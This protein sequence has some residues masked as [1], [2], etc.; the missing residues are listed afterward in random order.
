[1][2]CENPITCCMQDDNSLTVVYSKSMVT[3]FSTII[4]RVI[5]DSNEKAILK[6]LI[7]AGGDLKKIPV[8]GISPEMLRQKVKLAL[9][10]FSE[11]LKD[12]ESLLEE[13]CM[14]KRRLA[15]ANN[16]IDSDNSLS[17]IDEE[18]D[19]DSEGDD[20]LIS[21]IR[22]S[23]RLRTGLQS[24]GVKRLSDIENYS[25]MDY[26][27]IE[28]IGAKS[29]YELKGICESYGLTLRGVPQDLPADQV[30]VDDLPYTR[31][32]KDALKE[33]GINTLADCAKYREDQLY[34][35]LGQKNIVRRI[36][37][38]LEKYGLRLELYH[39]Q[40]DPI[41]NRMVLSE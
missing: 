12:F 4:D 10:V 40:I 19:E 32:V 33:N 28:N 27:R 26:R 16:K 31:W 2:S 9:I 35:I 1:M 15:I 39:V 11:Q 22:M 34:D 38:R 41:T 14:F 5:I 36:K 13:N 25:W 17:F 21:S 23:K 30:S 8:N 6:D 18:V 37:N 3:L 24:I 20:V 29:L 7:N